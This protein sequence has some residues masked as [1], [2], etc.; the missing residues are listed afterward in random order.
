MRDRERAHGGG[1]GA[2]GRRRRPT[3]HASRI[4]HHASRERRM[5]L[6]LSI[7]SFKQAWVDAYGLVDRAAA[8]GLQAVEIPTE[9]YAGTEDLARLREYAAEHGVGIVADG[10]V[11]EEGALRRWLPQARAV[12]APVLRVIVS[13]V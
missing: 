7:Y 8:A 5:R 10:G 9:N 6:G 1:R 3:I 11:I 13:Q 12:G 4:T 2:P